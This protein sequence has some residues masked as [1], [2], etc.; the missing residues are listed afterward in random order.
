MQAENTQMV[1]IIQKLYIYLYY[2]NKP[3]M[4]IKKYYLP[5]KE[6]FDA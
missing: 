6:D 4:V 5:N 2:N 3:C 1:Y